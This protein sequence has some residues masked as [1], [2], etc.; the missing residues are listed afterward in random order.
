MSPLRVPQTRRQVNH[1][2]NCIMEIDATFRDGPRAGVVELLIW[3]KEPARELRAEKGP[4]GL[5][6]MNVPKGPGVQVLTLDDRD[7]AARA[8]VKSGDIVLSINGEV[9]RLP[10]DDARVRQDAV[11]SVYRA[12]KLPLPS[13]PIRLHETRPS[14]CR[15]V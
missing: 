8:G 7:A 4:A 6:L 12:R 14:R 11:A 3:G 15:A 2:S 1:H 5:T 13:R 9:R 10:V